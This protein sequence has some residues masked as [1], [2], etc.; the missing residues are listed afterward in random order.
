[1]DEE[2]EIEA[3]AEEEQ[4]AAGEEG[5]KDDAKSVASSVTSSR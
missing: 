3:I 4:N 2:E 1:V 5:E